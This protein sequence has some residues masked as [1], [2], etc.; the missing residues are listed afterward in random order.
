MMNMKHS[1]ARGIEYP[2]HNVVK[3]CDQPVH[4]IFVIDQSQHVLQYL[5]MARMIALQLAIRRV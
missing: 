2:V 4:R 1:T 3:I 5:L